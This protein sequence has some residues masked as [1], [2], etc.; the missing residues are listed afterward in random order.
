[1]TDVDLPMLNGVMRSNESHLRSATRRILDTGERVVALLGLSFKPE[2]DDLRE[3]PNVEL[4]ELL[5]GKGLEVRI[6]DP[7]VHPERLFGA[8]RQYVERHLPHLQRMLCS[9]PEEALRRRRRRGR[10]NLRCG[11]PPALFSPDRPLSSS[12]S[13]AR[14]A[15]RSR[16]CPATRE[17]AGDHAAATTDGRRVLIIVQNL[18]VPFDRRV[19]LEACSLRDAGYEVT[20]VCPKGGTTTPLETPRRDPASGGIHRRRRRRS[21]AT[22]VYEYAYS[23]LRPRASSCARTAPRG[24]T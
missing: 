6:Y 8:N 13:T 3:S 24:S 21:L 1:M 18:P 2:T 23:W 10:R 16:R 15:R 20:V 12:T 9:T 7:I 5:V 19:W 17:S 22:Y 14:S 4:A 11:C